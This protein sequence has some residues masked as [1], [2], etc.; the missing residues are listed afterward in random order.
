MKAEEAMSILATTTRPRENQAKYNEAVRMAIDALEKQKPMKPGLDVLGIDGEKE[1]PCGNCGDRI[2][3][4][5]D[6]CPWCGQK[7]G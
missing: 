1:T 4:F 7:I 3:K 6:Y 5:W 2:Y